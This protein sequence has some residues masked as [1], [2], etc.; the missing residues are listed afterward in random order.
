MTQNHLPKKLNTQITTLCEEGDGYLKSEEY[1]QAIAKYKD[2]W[3]LLPEKKL[4]WEAATWILTSA[5]D[6]YFRQGD[7]ERSLGSFVGAV[8][9]PSG[10]GN[11]YIHLRLGQNY[12][13]LGDMAKAG[14]ELARA[15]MGAGDSIFKDED[16]K[17][18]TFLHTILLPPLKGGSDSI[19][20]EEQD[21]TK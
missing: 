8:Q 20:S 5:G 7:Y 6:A 19:S 2:A 13:E 10:L 21:Q 11:P 12:F 16:G 18:S 3:N 9:G 15:Y 4:D 1:E 14:D 17:Y